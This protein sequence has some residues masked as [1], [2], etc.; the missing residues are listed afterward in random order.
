MPVTIKD[1]D[2]GQ[3]NFIEGKGSIIGKEYLSVMRTHLSQDAASFNRY[4]YSLVDF[5]EV[6]EIHFSNTEMDKLVWL[7]QEAAKINPNPLVA[8]VAENDVLFGLSRMYE[9]LLAGSDWEIM[10][11]RTIPEAE[12]WIHARAKEKF[13]LDSLTFK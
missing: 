3:G 4:R 13:D 8:I 11:F 1:T 10:V 5:T 6:A 2:N 9:A 7:C 12:N